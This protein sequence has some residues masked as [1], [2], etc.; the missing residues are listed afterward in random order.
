MNWRAIAVLLLTAACTAADDGVSGTGTVEY[1]AVNVAP[2]VTGRVVTVSVQEG[3]E[4]SVG[5]PIATLTNAATPPEVEARAAAVRAAESQLRD[6]QVGARSTEITQ[7]R[8]QAVAAEVEAANATRDAERATSLFESG[9]ISRQEMETAQTRASAASARA[10]ALR[11]AA[12]TVQ[13]GARPEQI[14]A[15]RGQLDAARAALDAARRAAGELSLTA[16]VRGKVVVRAADPGEIV[17]AGVPI[18]TIARTD[19]LWVR[20][21]VNQHA[22]TRVRVGQPAVIRVDDD[23]RRFSGRVIALADRAEFTPRIALTE[24]ERADLLFA[25]KVLIDDSSGALKAGLPVTVRLEPGG[26][27]SARGP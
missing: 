13:A 23:S 22:F 20:I 6:L 21:F 12:R 15:A 2:L 10:A 8:A 16:P 19:S 17:P 1:T 24:R 26:V 9:A 5:Q 27:A 4:V 3:D 11:A 25:V 14:R 7:A 18:V